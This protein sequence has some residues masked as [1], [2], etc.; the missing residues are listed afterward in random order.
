MGVNVLLDS[1]ILIDHFNAIA[2][3]TEFLKGMRGLAA[4]SVITRA[5]VLAGFDAA[6]AKMALPLLDSFPTLAVD[7]EIADLA[8]DFRRTY[9]W[10]L[11]DAL[12]AAVAKHHQLRF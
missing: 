6:S 12:Q 9:R 5:E 1:V 10:R 8:A 11:P 3:A 2:A 4:V 7:R